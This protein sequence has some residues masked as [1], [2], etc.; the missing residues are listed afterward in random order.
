MDDHVTSLRSARIQA[1][2]P[3]RL[4]F[5][6]L[7]RRAEEEAGRREAGVLDFTFGDPH[8]MQMPAYVE[9]LREAAVPLD[10][11]WFAYKQSE[12]KAQDAAAASLERVVPLGWTGANLRMTTGG[13]GAITVAMKAVADPGDEVIYSLP[14]WFLYE[15]LAIEAGLVPVKVPA[16]QPSFDLD[17]DAIAAAI[18]PRTRIV[19]VNTPNN[20]S[21]RVY[22]PDTLLAL[23]GLLEQASAR[24]GRRIWLV[25]DEP[26]NR[27][28][29]DGVD[30]HSPAEFYPWTMLCYS[31]GKTLLA[32]GQR[33][34]YLAVP[35][36]LPEN[37]ELMDAVD[38]LQVAGG[39]L[40][41]NA[42]MQHA[43]PQLE[44][45]SI[46]M[47][48]LQDKRDRLV[49]ALLEMG[50]EVASP[51]GT[52]YLWPR[53]PIPD[54]EAFVA[55]LERRGVLVMPGA[56]FETPGW[57]R[58]CLTATMESIEAAL[59]HFAAAIGEVG[60]PSAGQA[61]RSPLGTSL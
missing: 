49:G 30:F 40:F 42:I 57:F 35:P 45:L 5:G 53:S 44:Q 31:Y 43:V 3:F 14:P 21:G 20:P 51:E 6:F 1:A 7:R 41:P 25:S 23:S 28:V 61:D 13:F 38:S 52:F 11:L 2:A 9:A 60:G 55:A 37:A 24:H 10:E 12:P 50:Y 16:L 47:H 56:L 22:P 4:L 58:I 48:A 33:L 34:G 8:E 27:I 26:Y 15:I 19:V 46:D 54:D 39:W 59:P 32:P 17:L 29:F 18:T 36:G